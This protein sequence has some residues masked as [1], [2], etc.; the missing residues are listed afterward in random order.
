MQTFLRRLIKTAAT[1]MCAHLAT[2][3]S[4]ANFSSRLSLNKII[5]E[6]FISKACFSEDV[7]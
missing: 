1:V 2:H 4:H 5:F 6:D 3:L 7:F